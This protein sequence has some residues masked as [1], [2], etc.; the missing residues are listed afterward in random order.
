MPY[1]ENN[2]RPKFEDILTVLKNKLPEI[3]TEG[4]LNFF[5]TSILNIYLKQKGEKYATYNTIIGV[6]ECAKLEYY[7]KRVSYYEDKKIKINGDVL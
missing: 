3:K 1:I 5:I 6:L 2:I 4:E 7:R